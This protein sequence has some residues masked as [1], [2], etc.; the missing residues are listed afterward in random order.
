[1]V[2]VGDPAEEGVGL[3]CRDQSMVI[4]KASILATSFRFKDAPVISLYHAED[5]LGK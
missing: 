2:I 1:M 4:N 5:R 3:R